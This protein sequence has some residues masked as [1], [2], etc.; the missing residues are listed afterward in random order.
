MF[1]NEINKA[2]ASYGKAVGLV[3]THKLWVLFLWSTLVY[4]IILGLGFMG[5]YKGIHTVS[6]SILQAD[7]VQKWSQYKAI[8]WLFTILS[9]SIYAI[10]FV[11]FFSF[12][13][14]VLLALASPFYSYVSEKTASILSGKSFEFNT[15]QFFQDV[16]RGVALSLRNFIKQF[17]FTILL[18]LFSFIPIVGLVIAIAFIALDSYY[19]GFSMLD[20]SCERKRWTATESIQFVKKHKGL[21]IGNGF[22]FYILFLIPI[23]GVIIGAPLSAIAAEISMQD[24]VKD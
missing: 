6:D 21:A 23:L 18:I 20:Y 7:F 15:Q 16:L 17:G 19:Y 11:V 13:K 9:W 14:F 8:A 24:A 10:S 1:F 12:Y 3:A 5:I 4:G 22:V 2:M